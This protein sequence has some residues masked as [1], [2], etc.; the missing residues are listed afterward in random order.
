MPEFCPNCHL[1]KSEVC[2][3]NAICEGIRECCL[4]L[5]YQG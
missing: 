1:E 4:G 2:K 5:D 3:E